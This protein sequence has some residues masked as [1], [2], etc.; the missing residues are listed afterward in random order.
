MMGRYVPLPH[1]FLVFNNVLREYNLY[2]CQA[3]QIVWVFSFLHISLKISTLKKKFLKFLQVTQTLLHFDDN[4]AVAKPKPFKYNCLLAGTTLSL[5]TVAQRT[6][7]V[8]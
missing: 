5:S 7:I 3:L 6:Y 8:V 4:L 2:K 1:M